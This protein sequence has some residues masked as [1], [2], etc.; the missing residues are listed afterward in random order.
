MSIFSPL[1]L[2]FVL[3]RCYLCVNN[4]ILGKEF[5]YGSIMGQ[6]RFFRGLKT[7]RNKMFNRATQTLF[8]HE[9][10]ANMYK[11][12]PLSRRVG[13]IQFSFV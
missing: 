11:F 9:C 4:K 10:W 8:M 5:F 7:T 6:L 3:L 2:N 13:G 1:I 12:I